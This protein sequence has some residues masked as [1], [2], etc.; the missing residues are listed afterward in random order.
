MHEPADSVGSRTRVPPPAAFHVMAKPAGAACNLTCAY[1]FFLKKSQLYAGA[2][3]LMT[4]EV[5]QSYLRQTIEGQ[6]VPAVSI[7]WQG[8]EPTL[9]GLDFFERAVACERQYLR[10][11]T[12]VERTLQTNGTLL[13]E[14]WCRFLRENRFLVGLSLDGPREMHD[15]WR[16][17]RA[18]RST[19]DRVM[20]AVEL[21]REHR[22]EFNIL[23][24]VNSCNGSYPVE[25]Y[26]FFRDQVG[27]R[28]V[29]FIPIVERDNETGY[30]EGDTVTDRSVGAEQYGGFLSG[31]FDEWLSRDVGEVF[32]LNFDFSLANWL[33][34]PS[35]CVFS[36]T[37]GASLAL[38]RNGDL[39]SCDHFVEPTYLLG[40]ILETPLVELVSS[41][42]QV[43]FGRNKCDTLPRYC[44]ECEVLFA[45]HGEC[46]KNRFVRTPD[47]DTGLNY[48]CAGYQQ[49]FRHVDRP[50]K[51]MASLIRAGRPV[52][53]IMQ[54]RAEGA[55]AG[56]EPCVTLGRNAPCPCD[57]GRKVKQCHG[58]TSRAR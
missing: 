34:R 57:S 37:C 2:P 42:Q 47:G 39:Y 52:P 6:R 15:A 29:Q 14:R 43:V 5:M 36:P 24:T 50:M 10:P 49:F 55:Q 8:G 25:V 33:G 40:N 26:R 12:S 22:V 7:A 18:H 48:L 16:R 53:D 35:V 41:E 44:R 54:I 1:C 9:A 51:L 23:C 4:D 21:L 30:Q 38:E 28:Y 13:D 27:A 31:V 32:V 46:P 11:G 58:K 3:P 17:D 19:F 56:A 20:H 45:C